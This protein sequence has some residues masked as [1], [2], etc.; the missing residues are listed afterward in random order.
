M[1]ISVFSSV[2]GRVYMEDFFFLIENFEKREVFGG[3]FDG[4]VG[5]KVAKHVARGIPR[6][7]GNAMSREGSDVPFIFKEVYK[8]VSNEID[9]LICG[10][11]A[12][13]FFIKK[14]KITL[15]NVGDSRAIIVHEG[16]VTHSTIDHS[17]SDP[18]ETERI[19]DAG[20]EINGRYVLRGDR[21]LMPTRT[22]GDSWF[23][24][25]GVIDE[26]DIYSWQIPQT[27]DTFL[28]VATDGVWD[29]LYNQDVASLI[30]SQKTAKSAVNEIISAIVDTKNRVRLDNITLIVIK[31]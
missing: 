1:D 20:G 14:N 17:V 30:F 26:P 4:H 11:T 10:C 25:V 28:V 27:F 9:S 22:I 6:Y 13:S 12:L 15:A 5:E 2:G 16:R 23:K 8:K 31:P 18:K 3:V 21:L 7:V 29:E 19:I 24:E